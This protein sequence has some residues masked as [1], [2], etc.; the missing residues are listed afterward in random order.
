MEF[1]VRDYLADTVLPWPRDSGPW[2][3]ALHWRPGDFGVECVGFDLRL[4][5]DAPTT[6]LTASK[7]RELR[8]QELIRK[9]RQEKYEEAGGNLLDAYDDAVANEEENELTALSPSFVD[10][11]RAEV[12]DWRERREG[13]RPHLDEDFYR[14]VATVYS[15]A[16]QR[17]EQPLQAVIAEMGPISKPSASRWV[18]QARELGYLPPTGRGRAQGNPALLDGEAGR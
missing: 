15:K 5:A 12:D 4:P 8:L 6:P 11:I 2:E 7:L 18:K 13:R 14:V 16:I 10:S 17:G 1:V 9:G 3:V